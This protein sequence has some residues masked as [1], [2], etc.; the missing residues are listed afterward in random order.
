VP[1][2]NAFPERRRILKAYG[3]ETVLSDA[4]EGSDGAIRMCREIYRSDPD[5]YFYP[6]QY[7][8]PANWKGALRTHRAGDPGRAAAPYA[9]RGG[10]GTSGTF[11]GVSPPFARRA[12]A[13]VQCIFGAALQRLHGLEG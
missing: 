6:D 2:A 8:N 7:N 3:A 11:M 5:S 13:R 12:A 1:A 10:H 4:A 9:F